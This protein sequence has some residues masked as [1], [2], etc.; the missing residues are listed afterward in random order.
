MEVLVDRDVFIRG[1]Q[2]AHNVVEPRQ[3]LQPMAVSWRLGRLGLSAVLSLGKVIGTGV[4][5]AWR[6]VRS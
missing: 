2:M 4:G 1:L 5:M 3:T 6:V